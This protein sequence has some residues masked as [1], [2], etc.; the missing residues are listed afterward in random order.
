M[1]KK[2]LHLIPLFLS[3]LFLTIIRLLSIRVLVLWNNSAYLLAIMII[4]LMV[5]IVINSM[6]PHKYFD[7][8]A[9]KA[10]QA[11]FELLWAVLGAF[12]SSTTYIQFM[13]VRRNEVTWPQHLC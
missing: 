4:H 3:I 2:V 13:K 6:A 10:K 1:E 12:S 7:A 5:V 11:G 9:N 8:T